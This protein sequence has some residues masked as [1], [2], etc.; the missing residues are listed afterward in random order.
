MTHHVE[1]RGCAAIGD[2]PQHEFSPDSTKQTARSACG[3]SSAYSP[4]SS[5]CANVA[6][7]ITLLHSGD[8][9]AASSAALR[10]AALPGSE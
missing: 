9:K 2:R 6:K 7:L 5:I 10:F 3:P 4:L 8:A 1:P